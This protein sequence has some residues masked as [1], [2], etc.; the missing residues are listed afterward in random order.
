MF[1][2]LEPPLL[3]GRLLL[4]MM[5]QLLPVTHKACFQTRLT[6][7]VVI[8]TSKPPHAYTPAWKDNTLQMDPGQKY[9]CQSENSTCCCIQQKE[10][11]FIFTLNHFSDPF[12]KDDKE[13]AGS[14]ESY[15]LILRWSFRPL[16]ILPG[17]W[18]PVRS[19]WCRFT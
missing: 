2:A 6:A 10:G 4:T 7:H 5:S 19:G 17:F 12:L 8:F 3:H 18:S 1:G 16:L 13:K 9:I 11:S 15:G 14:K